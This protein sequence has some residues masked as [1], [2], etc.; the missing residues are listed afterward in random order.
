MQDSDAYE[1]GCYIHEAVYVAVHNVIGAAFS[2]NHSFTPAEYR[3]MSYYA[4]Y[5]EKMKK[6]RLLK[7]DHDYKMEQVNKLFT[8]LG[9]MQAAFDATHKGNENG[10]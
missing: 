8:G 7:E 6:E 1:L 3:K 10:N 4:E 5:E 2:G 9:M